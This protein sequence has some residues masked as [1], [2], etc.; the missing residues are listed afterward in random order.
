MNDKQYL[1]DVLKSQTLDPDGQEMEDL[2]SHR[3]DVDTLLRTKFE[4]CSPAIRYG[5]SKAKGTMIK[6]SYDLDITCFFKSD[7]SAAGAT[8]QEIYENVEAAL[9][10][11]YMITRKP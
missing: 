9:V 4:K 2:R 10:G 8:L 5:G 6:E 3:S 11:D 7:E 1:E